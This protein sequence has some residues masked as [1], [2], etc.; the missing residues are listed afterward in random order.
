MVLVPSPY[1]KGK[2]YIIGSPSWPVEN[3]F[4]LFSN[5]VKGAGLHAVAMTCHEV[6]GDSRGLTFTR[7]QCPVCW[8]VRLALSGRKHE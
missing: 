3:Y 1:N 5:T 6:K 4:L 2:Q 7:G 8:G